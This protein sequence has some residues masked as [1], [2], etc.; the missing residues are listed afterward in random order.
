ANDL[1][2]AY[3]RFK[4]V[5]NASTNAYGAEAAYGMAYTRYLQQRYK[6]AEQAVF[7]L[8]KKYPS[9]DHWKAKGFILLGDVYVGLGD[10]FQA[11]ATLQSV[12]DHCTEPDLV[13]QASAR[14]A[15]IKEEAG[16]NATPASGDSIPMPADR[17]PRSTVQ[18]PWAVV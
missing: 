6:D 9:Y 16:T 14:L 5:D 7:S 18:P 10:L 15:N 4:S 8:V 12:V 13:Q 17:R 1:E 2:G 3:A 11:K